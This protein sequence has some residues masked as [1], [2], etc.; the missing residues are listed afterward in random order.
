M[1]KKGKRNMEYHVGTSL[2]VFYR[3]LSFEDCHHQ[4]MSELRGRLLVVFCKEADGN[5]E[6]ALTLYDD[7][8]KKFAMGSKIPLTL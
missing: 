2:E 7:T 8:V 4:D 1:K 3:S 6:E 5:F